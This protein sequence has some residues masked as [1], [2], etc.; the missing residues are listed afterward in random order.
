[1]DDGLL[2]ASEAAE[3][4]LSADVVILSACNTAAAQGGSNSDGLS[5]LSRAFLF[6]GARSLI[7][8]HWQVDDEATAELVGSLAIVTSPTGNRS[9]SLRDVIRKIRS[10]SDWASPGFWAAFVLVGV[11]D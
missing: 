3:L 1:M 8:S 4:N 6:A 2:T 5:G 7:V 11:P 9:K 10:T